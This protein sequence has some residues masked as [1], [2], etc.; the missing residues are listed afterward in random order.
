VPSRH[1]SHGYPPGS[2]RRHSVAPRRGQAPNDNDVEKNG[3]AVRRIQS[4]FRKKML[5][6]GLLLGAASVALAACGSSGAASSSASKS[7]SSH[8][9]LIGFADQFI[10]GNSWLATLAKGAESY[11]AAHGYQVV[12]ADAQ[13]DPTTQNQQIQTFINEGVK[14]IIIE[15]VNQESPGP[16]IAAAK[17]AGIPVIVVNDLVAPSLQKQVFCN[18]TDNGQAVGALVGQA[19]G[20]A[21]MSHYKSS[22]TI[23]LFVMALFPDS[24]ATQVRETGFLQGFD[25]YLSQHNGPHVDRIPDQYGHALPDTTLQVMRGVVSGH[26]NLN[27]IFNETDVVFPAVKDALSGAG[28]MNS[29]G[30]SSIIIGG[31]DGGIPQIQDMASD[32]KFAMTATGLDEPATQAAAAVQEAI[33]AAEHKAPIACSGTPPMHVL[34]PKVVTR[35]NAQQ[36]ASEN[37][38]FAGPAT[39]GQ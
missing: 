37:L 15:P 18:V 19:V 31:F 10:A 17:R 16:E 1:G 38:A 24:P 14:A 8:D 27:V 21:V 30:D 23:Q 2:A 13:G 5:T 33:A 29:K 39:G 28:V 7:G 36:Y 4:V 3:E 11:G 34:T 22:Q 9:P 20:Q 12:A 35:G 6:G 25:S 32:P 26:P